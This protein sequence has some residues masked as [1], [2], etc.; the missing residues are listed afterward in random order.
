[1]RLLGDPCK[2]T[3]VEASD[4][5]IWYFLFSNI[6]WG[7]D[8]SKPCFPSPKPSASKSPR[9]LSAFTFVTGTPSIIIKTSSCLL[10]SALSITHPFIKFGL[11]SSKQPMIA[12][13]FTGAG[14]APA[15]WT[16]E[17]IFFNFEC[18]L[19]FGII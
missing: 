2:K 18:I 10:M 19:L 1:M 7:G 4:T 5:S 13:R 17:N 11:H 14:F 9:N 6:A 8:H 16:D 15:F 12:L 3:P